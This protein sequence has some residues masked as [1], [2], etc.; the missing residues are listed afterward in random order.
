MTVATGYAYL[1]ATSGMVGVLAD[2]RL[3]WTDGRYAEIAVKA[4]DLG[5]R[6]AVVSAGLGLV[7]P[8]AAELTR[9]IVDTTRTNV[10]PISLWDVTRTFCYFAKE[11]QQQLRPAYADLGTDP[12][13]NEFVLV[14]FYADGSPGVAYVALSAEH[15]RIQFWKPGRDQFACFTIGAS[16]AKQIVQAA[17]A[18]FGPN[19]RFD[20]WN[21]AVASAMLYAMRAESETFRSIGG[22]IALGLCTV[23]H[24]SFVWPAVEVEGAQYY[25]GFRVPTEAAPVGIVRKNVLRL[26]VDTNYG[27]ELDRRVEDAKHGAETAHRQPRTYECDFSTINGASPFRRVEEPGAFR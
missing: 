25:R 14:G 10:P 13:Q 15:E 4:H 18:D 22:S 21:E 6:T 9:S 27:A 23:K 17:Y 3:S 11:I 2:S 1:T 7:G 20:D 16:P 5:A 8:Y 12:V 19:S 26:E 24:S